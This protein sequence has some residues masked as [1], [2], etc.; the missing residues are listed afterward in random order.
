MTNQSELIL[1]QTEDNQTH[2][3]V[4]LEDET[5]WLSQAQMVELFQRD[6]SVISRHIGNIFKEGELER[7]SNMQNLHIG[8]SD[9]PVTFHR[10]SGNRRLKRMLLPVKQ[11][12]DAE[13]G[14]PVKNSY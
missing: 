13:S 14:N 11:E 7:K 2:I 8:G 12:I 5:V 3:E 10:L 6:Q 1:Y 4:R 9:K